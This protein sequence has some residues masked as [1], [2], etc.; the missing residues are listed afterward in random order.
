MIQARPSPVTTEPL[1]APPPLGVDE[2][3]S[4]T[5]AEEFAASLWKGQITICGKRI[6]ESGIKKIQERKKIIEDY[7]KLLSNLPL[8]F[9]TLSKENTSTHHLCVL[10][11]DLKKIKLKYKDLFNKL[12]KKKLGINLHYLPIYNHP[13]YQKLKKYKKLRNTEDYSKSAISIPVFPGLTKKQ[14]IR[15]CKTIKK[16][17]LK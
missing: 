4:S 9:Q 6:G 1:E 5:L 13:Y 17:I 15:I 11:F 8:K 16:I 10:K 3:G 2:D 14:Q 7:R 12:R